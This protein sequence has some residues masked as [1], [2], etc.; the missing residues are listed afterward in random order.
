MA[1]K[2]N[3]GLWL[4]LGGGAAVSLAL[5]LRS[6]VAEAAEEE[7]AAVVT[8]GSLLQPPLAPLKITSGFGSRI[9]PITGQPGS[10]HPGLDFGA[11]FMQPIHAAESGIVTRAQEWGGYGN[12]VVI[13]HG[14]L[15][16]KKVETSYSH[17]TQIYVSKGEV[18]DGGDTIGGAGSTGRSTG[19]H[20]H[21]EVVADGQKVNPKD[22]LGL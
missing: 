5:A 14:T 4:L 18:V 10:W 13:N 15:G 7:E 11:D 16:G 22:Y 3:W 12:Q 19:V 6:A 1:D 20:L 9:D 21:F 2:G 8:A 17:L